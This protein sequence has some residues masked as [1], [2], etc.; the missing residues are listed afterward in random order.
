MK[1]LD[2]LLLN[3][4]SYKA[5]HWL[6]YPPNTD[7]TF[8]Y[9]ES[10]GGLYDR[11]V[12]FGLQAILKEYLA[13]PISHAD[14]DEARDLFAAH[15]EPFNDS[16]WRYIVDHHRGLLPVRIR[17]VPEGSVV[18]THQ[19][20]VTIESTDPMACWVPSY[21]ETLLLRLWYPVTVATIS[22]HAK[23]TIRQFLERTSDDPVGQLPFKLHDFGARGVS[24]AESAALGGAAHLVNFMGTDTVSGLMAAKAY[25]HEPMAGFSIPAA[26]HSTITSWGRE[27]EAAA[28]RNMLRQ[29]AKPGAIVAVVSDSY[30][31]YHAI[32]EHWG[33]TLKAEVIASGATVVVRPDSGDPVAVV[34]QCLELLDEAFGHTL[35]SKGY[36]VLNHVRVL[37]GDGIN[38]NSIRAILERVTS[39]GY[40]TDNV[41]FGMG[42]ALLQQLN[43]DTQKFA[44]KCSAARV[45]GNWIDVYKDPITDKGKQSKRGRMTLVQHREYGTFKTVSVPPEAASLTDAQMP[46]G[47]HDALVTVWEDGRIVNDWTFAAVR[48]RANAA[49]L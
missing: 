11:T 23:Q 5:S 24:S 48:A 21:L 45:D 28:Y 32:R 3:T 38:P 6:Q 31:I 9:V 19:A 1:C 15:G 44:L 8:F 2:N 43:R 22:W 41:A 37:Q 29:F 25:Y 40:A 33:K 49:R 7:A 27:N 46:L 18:P 14:V 4:D 13:K 47:F 12:F 26:E 36:R 16:G 39:A 20:L 42:G 30:D 17:A 10:R 35:N 34:H